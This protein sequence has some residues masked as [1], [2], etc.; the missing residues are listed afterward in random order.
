MALRRLYSSKALVVRCIK[1]TQLF[2][3]R[4]LRSTISSFEEAKLKAQSERF[5]WDR[6]L[7]DGEKCVGQT[8]GLI[9][10]K[11]INN[12]DET[13]WS[14]HMTRLENSEHPVHKTAR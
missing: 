1:D 9:G 14:D 10:L 11:S 4:G 6:V 3:V 13:N 8:Q 2:P 5:D 12:Y 7:T